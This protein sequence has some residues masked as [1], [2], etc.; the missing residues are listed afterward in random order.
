MIGKV[1]RALVIQPLLM[2]MTEILKSWHLSLESK[3]KRKECL[4]T[5]RA[6]SARDDACHEKAKSS[7]RLR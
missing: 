5:T 2:S 7:G 1:D 6:N 3:G 4:F